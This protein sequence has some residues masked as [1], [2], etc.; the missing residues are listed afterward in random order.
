M[1]SKAVTLAVAG[2][3]GVPVAAFAQN[4]QIYGKLYPE[5]V[6]AKTTGATVSQ[7]DASSTLAPKVG[8]DAKPRLSQDQGN[9]Y[10]G[11]R[12]TEDLGSGLK[13]IWQIESAVVLDTG[14][15]A[16]FAARDSFV[17]L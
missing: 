7:A 1:K 17:G 10:L 13:A 16:F 3:L 8:P 6:Y 11:F 15:K 12:G 5:L 2:A 14:D 4:V 9:S